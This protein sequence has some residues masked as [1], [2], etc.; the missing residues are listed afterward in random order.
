MTPPV[1]TVDPSIVAAQYAFY[2]I[3]VQA[4]V[5]V[6]GA[7]V[8]GIFAYLLRRLE[9]NGNRRAA[10]NNIRMNN[11]D[12]KLSIIH[13]HI[14]GR[15]AETIAVQVKEQVRN[16]VR[17]ALIEERAKVAKKDKEDK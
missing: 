5:T 10:Q 7:I 6:M 8:A 12:D 11:Q 1:T 14:N 9:T 17:E 16:A 4:V 15:V 3:I 2:S 13:D